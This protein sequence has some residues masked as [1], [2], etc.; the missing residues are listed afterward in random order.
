MF[1]TLVST[2][3]PASSSS[4]SSIDNRAI[5]RDNSTYIPPSLAL[6]RD[7]RTSLASVAINHILPA[8][9]FSTS[10]SIN[11]H[12][13]NPTTN[14][15]AQQYTCTLQRDTGSVIARLFQGVNG[16]LPNSES[17]HQEQSE[18]SCNPN[19]RCAKPVA[20]PATGSTI[21]PNERRDRE[22]YPGAYRELPPTFQTTSRFSPS[23]YCHR[24]HWY[25]SQ[26]PT[27]VIRFASLRNPT[28]LTPGIDQ[29]TSITSP[30]TSTYLN[31]ASTTSQ[32]SPTQTAT[33]NPSQSQQ[34]VTD[35]TCEPPKQLD[36]ADQSANTRLQSASTQLTQACE[37]D[38]VGQVTSSRRGSRGSVKVSS[39]RG[40]GAST[41][42]AKKEKT[43]LQ[44][45]S[46][47][48][49]GGEEVTVNAAKPKK[50]AFSRFLSIL[51]CC[52][53]QKDASNSE[54]GQAVPSKRLKTL[55][56]ARGRQATPVT[57]TQN[58]SA[59]ESSNTEFKEAIEDNIGGKRYSELTPSAQP[60]IIEPPK[61]QTP[62]TEK[63]SP[64][65][66]VVPLA[67][68]KIAPVPSMANDQ[69]LPPLPANTNNNGDIAM[70]DT[71]GYDEKPTSTGTDG[72][73]EAPMPPTAGIAEE[74]V[75]K[76]E[77]PIEDRTPQ[78]EARDAEMSDAPPEVPSAEIPAP[79]QESPIQSPPQTNLP[80]PPPPPTS[81]RPSAANRRT[82]NV[83]TTE[84]PQGLLPPMADRFRG[85]KCLVLDL[86]ETL[87][88]SSFKVRESD[89][90][91]NVWI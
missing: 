51:N 28:V 88:H 69:P 19:P 41:K 83:V 85:K 3:S 65:D 75:S 21:A 66:E 72:L 62:M 37:A 49:K 56:S 24:G 6:K 77:A 10:S 55:Q 30:G 34:P 27:L 82:S 73:V 40:S 67:E 91:R 14:E 52:G 7:I 79:K 36:Q 47:E 42:P 61:K 48:E 59:G 11:N 74:G 4:T 78:Q 18:N 84:Q 23:A 13:P 9:A 20:R 33:S 68:P 46:S 35:P 70:T 12:P 45:S 57:K 43:P 90:W 63:S 32:T 58:A 76:E 2:S 64:P 15:E 5:F 89:R 22:P 8:F 38:P 60:K 87:V 17:N 71:P 50:K 1:V 81:G 25:V 86:D 54:L 39:R 29:S 16:G 26:R 53:A 31:S 80:P 44:A